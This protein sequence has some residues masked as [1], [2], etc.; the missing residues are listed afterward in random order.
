MRGD[1]LRSGIHVAVVLSIIAEFR[2]MLAFRRGQRLDIGAVQLHGKDLRLPRIIFVGLE[3]GSSG[4]FIRALRI[5]VT[6]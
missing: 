4:S 3:K 1:A 2:P 6:S 5:P